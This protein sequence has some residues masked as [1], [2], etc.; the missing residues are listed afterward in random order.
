MIWFIYGV[1]IAETK[2][3]NLVLYM[4]DSLLCLS[5]DLLY[6]TVY[7]L[8]SWLDR[9]NISQTYSFNYSLA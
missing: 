7:W 2:E 1:Y 6:Q 4:P 3:N 9:Y 5:I 8:P